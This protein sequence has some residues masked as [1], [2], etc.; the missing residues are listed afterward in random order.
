[1]RLHGQEIKVQAMNFTAAKS[2]TFQQRAK[3][4]YEMQ[5]YSLYAAS[6]DLSR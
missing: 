4:V 3:S 6:D 2:L 1:M 5:E